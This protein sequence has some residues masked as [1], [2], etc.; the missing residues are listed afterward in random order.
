VPR[1]LALCT[2][3]A[4]SDVPLLLMAFVDGVIFNRDAAAALVPSERHQAGLA[5]ADALVEL[6]AVDIR[7]SGLEDFASHASYARRQLKRWRR[8]WEESVTD[9]AAELDALA[10]ADRLDAAIPEQ[11]EVVLVHGDYHI[12]NVMFDRATLGVRAIIDWELCTL[13]DPLADLGGLLAYWPEPGEHIG[14]GPYDVTTL[15]GFP[16]RAEMAARYAERSGRSLE[17]LAFWES[18]ACW[19]VAVIAQGVV[20]RRRDKPDNDDGDPFDPLVIGRMLRRAQQLAD[21]AGL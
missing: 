3:P 12:L 9:D 19:K 21:D 6:H 13:G 11:R 15:G 2:D 20:R 18:L 17:T 8:Q 1:P 16:T 5:L 7:R 14:A 10:I 4:V